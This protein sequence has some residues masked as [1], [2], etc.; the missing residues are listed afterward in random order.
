VLYAG[1]VGDGQ[2][3][4]L[5]LPELAKSLHGRADFIVIGDGGRHAEL[6]AAVAG[7]DNVELRPPVPRAQLINA[8]QEADVLFL[9]LGERRA[10][11]RVLPSKLFEYAAL[12]KPVLAGVAG[13]AAQF[14][15]EEIGNAAVFPPCN[16]PAAVAAFSSLDLIVR[17]RRTFVAKY[18]RANIARDM[19]D[20]ILALLK[21]RR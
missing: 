10:F 18:A 21:K 19:A 2:A 3:L 8:Y 13:Y 11:E 14:V 17:P 6:A 20:D 5:I 4:H 12:G 15:N 1:N 16:V 9:H 7:L